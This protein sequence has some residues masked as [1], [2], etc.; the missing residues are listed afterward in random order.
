MKLEYITLHNF[1]SIYVGM[2]LKKIHIDLIKGYNVITL[3]LGPNGSGKTSILSN[4]HPFAYPGNMDVRSGTDLILP[5]HDGYKE[6]GVIDDDGS[7][8]IIKHFYMFKNKNRVLKSFISKDGVEL[9]PNGNVTSFTEA[10]SMYLGLEP[11]FLKLL[12]LGSNVTSFINMKSLDRKKFTSQLLSD[13]D[14]YT[15]YY[16]KINDDSRVLKTL[17]KSATD[18]MNRLNIIDIDAENREQNMRIEKLDELNRIRDELMIKIGSIKLSIESLEVESLNELNLQILEIDNSI[19][20]MKKQLKSLEKTIEKLGNMPIEKALKEMKK[21][22]I[23]KSD[24]EKEITR[25]TLMNEMHLN[26]LNMLFTQRDSKESNLKFIDS[27]EQ[28]E[29]LKA[30]KQE[31]ISEINTINQEL[32]GYHYD[33]KITK[34]EALTLVKVLDDIRYVILDI[35]SVSPKD[36]ISQFMKYSKGNIKSIMRKKIETVDKQML[37]VNMELARDINEMGKNEL[38]VMYRMCEHHECPYIQYYENTCGEVKTKK[39]ELQ[40]RLANL[41]S[42]RNQYQNILTID[43]H[44]NTIKYIFN[45]NETLIKVS[46][47]ASKI[48]HQ[49]IT[50]CINSKNVDD[51]LSLIQEIYEY[52]TKV[53]YKND[54]DDKDSALMNVDKEIEMF[55]KGSTTL[56]LIRNE[57]TTINLRIEEVNTILINNNDELESLGIKKTEIES[58]I[59][60]LETLIESSDI[61]KE[62]N[63]SIDNSN[64]YRD[65]LMNKVQQLRELE[66]SMNQTRINLNIVDRDTSS[67]KEVINNSDRKIKD[68][69][70]LQEQLK[71]LNEEYDDIELLKESLSSNKGIPLLFIQLY[72]RSTKK[73]INELLDIVYDGTLQIETFIVND[74]EFRIPYSKNGVVVEDVINASD[75]ERAFISLI[76]SLALIKQSI[77]KYNILLLDEV[78]AALD[79]DNRTKFLGILETYIKEISCEQVFMTTHNN[80]FD[81]YDVNM[82]ITGNTELIDNYKKSNV[83][84]FKR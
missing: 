46:P 54:L 17:I 63:N 38:R 61:K 24:I 50:N 80:A 76:I 49:L 29:K 42:L 77:K 71:K 78:D 26:E 8:Y 43:E 23:Q 52:I 56:E 18:K 12:R 45:L 28:I 74:K 21:L 34:Q 73:F 57:V 20:S 37:I 19:N 10:V 75:G 35:F 11:E 25:L 48:N 72:L 62:L 44:M 41:D 47:F 33:F 6:V 31:L 22:D 70:E 13:V 15:A 39:E 14:T 59:S 32:V 67:I 60:D 55:K 68:Y 53:E 79:A 1:A 83:V 84:V 51:I 9:N 4:L 30:F 27:S 7:K 58:K 40:T 69:Y 5:E 64:N 65:S 2:K 82:I 36:E 16:K 81:N 66:E 3:L